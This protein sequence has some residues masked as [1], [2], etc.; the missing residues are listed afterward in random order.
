M[1]VE[2]S[3]EEAIANDR[4]KE[5]RPLNRN[6]GTGAQERIY[7][8]TTARQKETGDRQTKAL[9]YHQ[10]HY[11]F[12]FSCFYFSYTP[13]NYSPTTHS[14]IIPPDG[15]PPTAPRSAP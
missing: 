11:C 8:Y 12:Y 14:P 9:H 1:K 3:D 2:R 10:I 13:M 6:E 4:E 7:I 5:R 15:A